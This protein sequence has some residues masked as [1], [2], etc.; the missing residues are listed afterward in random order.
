MIEHVQIYVI[1]RK[2]LKFYFVG[3]ERNTALIRRNAEKLA[4]KLTKF[5][6]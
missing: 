2:W 3:I 6:F 1:A 5:K 4:A